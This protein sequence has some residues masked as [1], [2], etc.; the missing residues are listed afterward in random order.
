[1][2]KHLLAVKVRAVLPRS[3]KCLML[4]R[5]T[6]VPWTGCPKVVGEDK[7]GLD[8]EAVDYTWVEYV[9]R[10]VPSLVKNDAKSLN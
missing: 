10:I 2:L 8:A 4:T 1:M 9:T 3:I 7:R 6:N 5:L